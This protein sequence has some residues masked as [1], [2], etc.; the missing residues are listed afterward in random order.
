MHE[1][2]KENPNA[3]KVWKSSGYYLNQWVPTLKNSLDIKDW[4]LKKYWV[5]V[6]QTSDDFGTTSDACEGLC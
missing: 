4:K 6:M 1:R 3:E 5:Y 2:P